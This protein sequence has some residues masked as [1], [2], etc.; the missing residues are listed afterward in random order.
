M[1]SGVIYRDDCERSLVELSLW[2]REHPVAGPIILSATYIVITIASLPGF[3]LALAAG[4]A[5]QEAYESTG[6]AVLIGGISVFI[7]AWVGSN[8]ALLLARYLFRTYALKLSKKYALFRAIDKAMETN[9]L[10]FTFLMRLCP[11]IPYNAY[12]YV[13][14]IT[15]VSLR[16]FA[17]GGIGMLPGTFVYVFIGTTIGSINDAIHGE[18]EHGATFLIL[19]IVGSVSALAAITYITCVIKRYLKQ[20]LKKVESEVIEPT[21]QSSQEDEVLQIE[22]ALATE[23]KALQSSSPR[24]SRKVSQDEEENEQ[25]GVR[26]LS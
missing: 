12:N 3:V 25:P 23:A 16:D 8:L 20:S 11:L 4:V 18:F 13:L 9:G 19:L 1:V 24:S 21:K 10:K 2:L 26:L 7:G 6:T 14:G 15:A 17:I 5:F 22:L